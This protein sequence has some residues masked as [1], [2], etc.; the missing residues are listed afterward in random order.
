MAKTQDFLHGQTSYEIFTIGRVNKIVID[1]SDDLY[2]SEFDLGKIYYESLYSF[3]SI[4]NDSSV[5]QAAYPIFRFI[6]QYPLIGEIVLILSGPSPQ[7]N[8]KVSSRM[9]YYF[10]PFALWG[11]VNHNALPNLQE[12][13]LFLNDIYKN[14]QYKYNNSQTGSEYPLGKYFSEKIIKNLKPFE[15]DLLLEGRFGQSIRFGSTTPS[16]KSENSWSNLG[17]NGSPITIIR[18]GQGNVP[19]TSNNLTEVKNPWS[20]TVENINYD[21]SSI[22]LTSDQSVQIDDLIN[23]PINSFGT[24][25]SLQNVSSN[26]VGLDRSPVSNDTVSP[27]QQDGSAISKK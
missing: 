5:S 18:N 15:G 13:A 27:S 3:K 9:S 26:I 11:A 20:P 24:S 10:P 7:L 6:R 19:I 8:D 25:I 4:P 12:Y 22:Y 2:S 21:Q 23:F 1:T 16:K 17:E 14:P